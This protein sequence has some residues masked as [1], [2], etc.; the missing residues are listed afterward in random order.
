MF[1]ID[2]DTNV[3]SSP[4]EKEQDLIKKIEKN[5][6]TDRVVTTGSVWSHVPFLSP[7][8]R[9]D[10]SRIRSGPSDFVRVQK[11]VTLVLRQ[12]SSTDGNMEVDDLLD[13][14]IMEQR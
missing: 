6:K 14:T 4:R 11:Y 2:G 13:S 10:F 3:G 12:K 7:S 5:D 8:C 1:K 9:A